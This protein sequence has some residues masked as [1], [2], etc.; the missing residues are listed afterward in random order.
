MIKDECLRHKHGY[1]K[2]LRFIARKR[3]LFWVWFY[4]PEHVCL[5]WF[6]WLQIAVILQPVML[7]IRL[8]DDNAVTPIS[9]SMVQAHLREGYGLGQCVILCNIVKLSFLWSTQPNSILFFGLVSHF[10]FRRD[11]WRR[12]KK[13]HQKRF[14]YNQ[15][16][17]SIV[18]LLFLCLPHNKQNSYIVTVV[19]YFH[20]DYPNLCLCLHFVT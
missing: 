8:S 9:S 5:F 19:K 7:H 6:L 2:S 4:P 14:C 3:F 15:V 1:V 13:K 20:I 11:N 12:K 17:F 18:F 16:L 10:W